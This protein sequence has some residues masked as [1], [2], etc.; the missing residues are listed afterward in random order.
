MISA[1]MLSD[2]ARETGGTLLGEAT[3]YGVCTDTRKV[4][5]GDVFVA[6][7]G[8]HYDGHQ[9]VA[10]AIEAGAVAAVV[11]SDVKADI[12]LLKVDD[13]RFALGQIA[14]LNRRKFKGPVIALTGSAGKTTTKE[15]VASILSERG[16]VL[17]TQSNF[18]N[19]IGV[20]LTL[21]AIDSSHRFAVV[22]MGASRSGDIAYLTQFAEPDIA[23][24]TNAMA[25]HIEGF[26]SL[27]GVAK[28]K[29]EIF[30]SVAE[31]GFAL[32][33][34][35][36]AFF[37]QWQKQAGKASITTFSKVD[38]TADFYASDIRVRRD[39]STQFNLHMKQHAVA[40]QLGLLG[41]HNV[42]NA[43]AAATAAIT[44]G[45]TTENVKAGLERIKPVDGRLKP[46]A[47]PEQL[48]I[49]DSYNASPGAVKAAIDV[50]SQFSGERCLILGTMGELGDLAEDGHREVAEYARENGI[51]QLFIV[52]DY[53]K[54][55][56]DAFGDR[57]RTFENMEQLLDGVGHHL[58]SAVV[59]VKGSRS[60]H[61]ERAVE[62]LK[63][64]NKRIK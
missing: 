51:E 1:L 44:A 60:A 55:V 25:A 59:L 52:G 41:E 64:N 22:E 45:A 38:S 3:A 58:N 19:E 28:T 36:D 34:Q 31:G 5:P 43:V 49:D 17:A 42:F 23:L 50:L 63:N 4:T 37:Q 14:R 40:I 47:Y 21:L 33:N 56:A 54:V 12:P 18:N 30:E 39:G 32:L 10:Q 9:F 26:G 8:T 61:M 20:P 11:S 16:A 7:V 62:A 13:T 29:G 53:A 24:L 48:I 6:L 35:D 57:C 27:E 2:I 15:M 46:F